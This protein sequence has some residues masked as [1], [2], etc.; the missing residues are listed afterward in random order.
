MVPKRDPTLL[1]ENMAGYSRNA[2]LYRGSLQGFRQPTVVHTCSNP[3]AQMVYRVPL[4]A[5]LDFANSTWMEFTDP[6]MSV[7]R[8]P[9]IE[10]QYKR[11]YFFST[12]NAPTY[13]PLSEIQ[14]GTTPITLGVPVPTYAPSVIATPP[15]TSSTTTA[16]VTSTST[17]TATTTGTGAAS[18]NSTATTTTANTGNSTTTSSTTTPTTSAS[19]STTGSASTTTSVTTSATPVM[20]TVAYVYTWVTSFGEEGP[21]SPPTTVTSAVGST[22]LVT[23]IPP[24]VAQ[25]TN[26]RLTTTRVYRTVTDA[27]G[28]A[29]YYFVAKFNISQTVLNDTFTDTQIA[30]GSTLESTYW[31]APPSDLQGV[32]V[33]ANGILVGWS[34]SRELWFC[35]PYR[36]HAWPAPY[37]ISV[38]FTIVGLAAIGTSLVVL[39]TG[40][41]Y[42]ATGVTPSAMSLSKMPVH[43]PCIARSSIVTSA[44]G[45]YYTSQNGIVMI[46][47]GGATVVSNNILTRWDWEAYNP[48]NL[49]AARYNT[50]YVAY[51]KGVNLGDGSGDNGIV[52]D[53]SSPNVSLNN[54]RFGSTVTNIQQD[55][56]T[57]DIFVLSNGVVYEFDAESSTTQQP[58][59]WRSKVFQFNFKQQFVAAYVFF[60]LPASVTIP[61]PSAATRNTSQTQSFNPATQ[62][63]IM[64]VYADGNIVYVREIQKSGELIM[65]P[66]GFKA[67]FW[68]F[69]F[70]GQVNIKNVQIATSVKELAGI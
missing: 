42:I 4:G 34:N 14:A 40:N 2:W 16:T 45:V 18:G 38:D 17:N 22:F 29:T 64:R 32:V 19:G 70:E 60:D 62:Y 15:V 59:L 35:E 51:S 63:L 50:A 57:G 68:Q 36:P 67:N 8:A 27:A 49:A 58:Y 54:L 3:A 56:L 65:F 25:S 13:S 33:M 55:E 39:T 61:T 23:V 24:T 12:S 10:D 7:A 6:Y 52:I 11:Y 53:P 9:M 30:G 26:R 37:S 5:P 20:E 41:P 1:P 28:N 66:S 21:P 47:A 69:E 44:E 43:E 46:N 31:S 48:A